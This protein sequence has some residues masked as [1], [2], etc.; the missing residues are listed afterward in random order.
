MRQKIAALLDRIRGH[1][2][3]DEGDIVRT[4]CLGAM[5]PIPATTARPIALSYFIGVKN[6]GDQV[7][8]VAVQVRDRPAHVVEAALGRRASAGPWQ[9]FALGDRVVACLGRRT[10]EP[11]AR[12]RRCAGRADL[13]AARQADPHA[14]GRGARRPARRAAGR[15][16][17]PGRAP[18]GRADAGADTDAAAGSSCHTSGTATIRTSRASAGRRA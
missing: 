8:P 4:A 12:F 14:S 15:S 16:G 7:S 13:G 10:D 1:G 11:G 17:L 2:P 3:S 5:T 6:I 18:P 9:H